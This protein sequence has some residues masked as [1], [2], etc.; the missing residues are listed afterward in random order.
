MADATRESSAVLRARN[1]RARLEVE[2]WL[3][4]NCS[5]V[6][7]LGR[8]DVQTIRKGMVGGWRVKLE[9]TGGTRT[10]DIM[11]PG[12]FPF[13]APRIRLVDLP[14]DED[15]PHVE[16]DNVLCLVPETASF[17]PD[18]PAGGV[19]ALL[20]MVVELS[21]LV[22]TGGA[23]EEFRS[24]V[25]SYWANRVPGGQK[26]VVSISNPTPVSRLVSVWNGP[27]CRVLADTSEEL[28]QWL[29]NRYPVGQRLKF[30]VGAL[31]W[32]GEP[33]T[34]GQFPRTARDILDLAEAAGATDI[35]T[36]AAASVSGDLVVGLGMTTAN[37][38]AVAG[39]TIPRP[40]PVRGRDLVHLGF[41]PGKTPLSLVAKR[42]FGSASI[43]RADWKRADHSWVH[44]RDQDQRAIGLKSK[45]VVVFGCGSIGAPVAVALAQA[46]ITKFVFVDH[47]VLNPSNLS[48]HPLGAQYLGLFKAEALAAKLKQDLPHLR[49]QTVVKRME[50]VLMTAGNLSDVDLI[51]SAVGDWGAEAMLD[52]WSESCGRPVP[53]VFGWT[54][55]HACAGHAVAVMKAGAAFRDGFD[56]TGL[57]QLRVTEFASTTVRQEPACGAVFQP[58][59]PIELQGSIGIIAELALDALLQPP[60]TSTHRIW[61]GR[62]RHLIQVGG[63]WSS[64]W[65]RLAGDRPEGGFQFERPWAQA[66]EEGMLAA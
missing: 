34:V 39:L 46:G 37:G 47:D 49:I 12:A 13:Q 35:L 30:D 22:A 3:Y 60:A 61:V 63:N 55:A 16:S 5:E 38:L 23:D 17:D 28:L 7:Q 9:V 65:T 6:R 11:V 50:E 48:R 44:G 52:A 24:E 33:L 64:A 62:E 56:P 1:R 58:Y 40:S 20:N 26:E 18:D 21:D 36:K 27:I 14:A 54:E 32:L 53:I 19:I 25:L 41:R 8:A 45:K 43:L 59:G 2:D 15:W 4:A 66:L 10:I 29:Y 51:V 31:L 42:F 57:P